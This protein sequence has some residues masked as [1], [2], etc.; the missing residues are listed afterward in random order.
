MAKSSDLDRVI[1]N[2]SSKLYEMDAGPHLDMM[3]VDLIKIKD[4]ILID[5]LNRERDSRVEYV[6]I[7]A[8]SHYSL[9]KEVTERLQKGF[10]PWGD[11]FVLKEK[12]DEYLKDPQFYY[13]QAVIKRRNPC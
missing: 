2:M 7:R 9:E 5:E 8:E 1:K 4:E 10:Q 12:N 11:P 3:L 13:Y 6:L